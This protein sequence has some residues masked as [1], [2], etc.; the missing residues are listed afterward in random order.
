MPAF[1]WSPRNRRATTNTIPPACR[2]RL[3]ASST[4]LTARLPTPTTLPFARVLAAVQYA[5]ALAH[6]SHPPARRG[7]QPHHPVQTN[8]MHKPAGAAVL[9]GEPHAPPADVRGRVRPP[10]APQPQPGNAATYRTDPPP[11]ASRRFRLSDAAFQPVASNAGV[12]APTD[13]ATG[14]GH[15]QPGKAQLPFP[16]SSAVVR[17]HR[18]AWPGRRQ[19]QGP[20]PQR[21]PLFSHHSVV[22]QRHCVEMA[23]P[24]GACYQAPASVARS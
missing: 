2:L 4:H 11:A 24:C 8:I 13:G 20:A 15:A 9:P 1:C 5:G 3:P 6:R 16:S 10:P 19:Q 18:R 17:P 12:S 7:H 21:W 14:A 22:Q 23:A